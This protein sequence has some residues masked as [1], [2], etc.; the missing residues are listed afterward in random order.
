[1]QMRNDNNS[2][3][4]RIFTDLFTYLPIN[5]DHDILILRYFDLKDTYLLIDL[6]INLIHYFFDFKDTYLLTYL[7]TWI[8]IFWSKEYLVTSRPTHHFGSLFFYLKNTYLL[9]YLSINLDH[10]ILILKIPTYLST[11]PS[12]WFIIFLILKI[13]TYLPTYLST[14]ITI[15]WSKGYLLTSWPTHQFGSLSFDLK[16]TYLLSYL[17]INLGDHFLFWS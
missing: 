5:L 15:F 17:P 16:D 9:T 13:H 3:V 7:S 11:Y 8:M 2:L 12:I 6:P 14:R 1:M 4:L 10:D